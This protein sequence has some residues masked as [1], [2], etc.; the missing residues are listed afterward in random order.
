MGSFAVT[1]A[2]VVQW[3]VARVPFYYTSHLLVG[4]FHADI[5]RLRAGRRDYPIP[6]KLPR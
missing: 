6:V 3:G 4:V 1:V 5:C 2:C